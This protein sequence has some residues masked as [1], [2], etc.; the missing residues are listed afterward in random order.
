MLILQPMNMNCL[1][2]VTLLMK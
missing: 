1:F 2:N